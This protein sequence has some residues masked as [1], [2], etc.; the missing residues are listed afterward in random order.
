MPSISGYRKIVLKGDF[1]QHEEGPLAA[2][3]SPGMNLVMTNAAET[4]QRQTVTPGATLVSAAGGTAT[5]SPIKVLKEDGLVGG[6]TI[7]DAYA[8]G[9][10]AMYYVPKAGDVIQV[11]VASGQTIT[12]GQAGWAIASGK[13]NGG[14]ADPKAVGEFLEASGGALAADTHMRL[15]VY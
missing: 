2:I 5:A 11:L 10:N 14:A 15:R 1:G 7:D 13:W 8:S 9:D 6:K 4:Q 3:A 12:K